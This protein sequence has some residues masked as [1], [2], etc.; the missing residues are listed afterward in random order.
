MLISILIPFIVFIY[1]IS[2]S[3]ILGRE[4]KYLA[5]SLPTIGLLEALKFG[6][7]NAYTTNVLVLGTWVDFDSLQILWSLIFS[8]FT[9]T[10]SILITFLSILIQIYSL[11]YMNANLNI[12]LFLAYMNLFTFLMIWFI[13]SNNLILNLIG[14]EGIGILSYLLINFWTLRI[15]SNKASLKAIFINKFGDFFFIISIVF[16]FHTFLTTN[17]TPINTLAIYYKNEYL[18]L[19]NWEFKLLSVLTVCL[20]LAAITK[21]AQ[22]FL[23][24]WLPDAME[25]PTPVSSLIHSAT[26]VAAGFLLLIKYNGLIEQVSIALP[27]LFL[28]G[29]L[30][31]FISSFES[32]CLYDH[33]SVL[34][35]STCDQLGMLFSIYGCG[36]LDLSFF[37]FYNHAFYKSLLFLTLG[38]LIHQTSE[39]DSRFI[40]I[41]TTQTPLII[42]NYQIAILAL[43]GFPSIISH[44][45]KALIIN[46]LYI[47]NYSI[48]NYIWVLTQSVQLLTNLNTLIGS[49]GLYCLLDGVQK[50]KQLLNNKLIYQSI[51]I[52]LP[53]LILTFIV[54]CSG[55]VFSFI[56]KYGW[57]LSNTSSVK[58]NY[59]LNNYFIPGH[60]TL[61][62]LVILI[63]SI[64]IA[65]VVNYRQITFLNL[66]Q[67][68]FCQ[69]T[70]NFNIDRVLVLISLNISFWSYDIFYLSLN[71]SIFNLNFYLRYLLFYNYF[72]V[73]LYTKLSQN[74]LL[75]NFI[76]ILFL[77]IILLI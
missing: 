2:L 38:A 57:F 49:F 41:L 35:G 36:N 25:G 4:G 44:Y 11:S 16:I 61:F 5:I 13:Y 26:M 29:F 66:N 77:G 6:L 51:Y 18:Q 31:S 17:A 50:R 23:S 67:R 71:N 62:S 19:Y 58:T 73:S 53:L 8:P 20:L 40:T 65:Y 43:L 15:E 54:L 22:L 64:I 34:A 68:V 3:F 59:W 56:H 14:W 63:L 10:T 9:I 24:L 70:S 33:K 47:Q 72:H 7:N 12:I 21:S 1:L 55:W 27:L 30:T 74:W 45:S 52:K 28:I 42:S 69:L 37:H 39:Q 75:S 32:L 76:I 46:T 48:T 60:I